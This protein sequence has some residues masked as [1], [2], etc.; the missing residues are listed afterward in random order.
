MMEM[1]KKG[2]EDRQETN[3]PVNNPTINATFRKLTVACHLVRMK[4]KSAHV[5][6]EYFL[7]SDEWAK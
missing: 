3:F 5:L 4:K 1:R 7:N 6:T 2:K